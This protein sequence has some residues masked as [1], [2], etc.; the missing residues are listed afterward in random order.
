MEIEEFFWSR[1][2]FERVLRLGWEFGI[3]FKVMFRF[4]RFWGNVG[5]LVFLLLFFIFF[6]FSRFLVLV[7][8]F[9]FSLEFE[10]LGG[11]LY[12]IVRDEFIFIFFWG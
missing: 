10:V 9:V 8:L 4:F 2:V 1:I 3:V 12:V 5:L 6:G 7:V 11:D